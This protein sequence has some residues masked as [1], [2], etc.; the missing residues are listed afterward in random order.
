MPYPASV[1][2]NWGTYISRNRFPNLYRRTTGIGFNGALGTPTIT[3]P[4]SCFGGTGRYPFPTVPTDM[5]LRSSDPADSAA[6]TGMR[7]IQLAPLNSSYAEVSAN[8]F[9][10]NG[11]TPVTVGLTQLMGNNAMRGL[12]A[13][14]NNTNVGTIFL[15]SVGGGTVYGVIPPG[16]GVAYHAPHVVPA[17]FNLI[18]PQLFLNV[19]S[20]GGGS[21]QFAQMRTWFKFFNAVA[22]SCSFMPLP[23][24]N[25][26]GQPYP[27]IADPPIVVSEKSLFDLLIT[28]ASGS[29]PTATV[30]WNG[31]YEKITT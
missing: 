18:I 5:Q 3:S 11:T 9:T 23:I 22:N 25:T 26:N 27:H 10:L 12:T 15:E 30:G 24:G 31:F 13:G 4:V 16:C 19:G 20:A 17:G 2:I 21:A 28:D 14:S 1:A 8:V 7:T 6:G 29:N